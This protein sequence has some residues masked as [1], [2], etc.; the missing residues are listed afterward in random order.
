MVTKGGL[1]LGY[2][3]TRQLKS[4]LAAKFSVVPGYN[5]MNLNVFIGYR[6]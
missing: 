4:G 6:F 1:D 5:S 3:F 2:S